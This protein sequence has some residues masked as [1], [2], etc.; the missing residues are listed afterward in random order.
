MHRSR[1][2]AHTTPAGIKG[3]GNEQRPRTKGNIERDGGKGLWESKGI[4]GH[5][6]DIGPHVPKATTE[7][8]DNS[9]PT[10]NSGPGDEHPD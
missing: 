5:E 9:G 6:C 8:T 7:T 4:N 1:T 2:V 10:E 3:H